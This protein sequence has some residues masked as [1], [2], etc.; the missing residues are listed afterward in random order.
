MALS[1]CNCS[2]EY[3]SVTEYKRDE[4][5]N[6]DRKV[7]IGLNPAAWC[8]CDI[9]TCLMLQQVGGFNEVLS[10]PEQQVNEQKALQKLL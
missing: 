2:T 5:R 10:Q 4:D 1:L 8:H 3:K 9:V 7:Q 6:L